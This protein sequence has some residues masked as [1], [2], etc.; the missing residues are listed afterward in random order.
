[1]SGCQILYTRIKTDHYFAHVREPV[2]HLLLR[3][4]ALPA[5]RYLVRV[6]QVRVL[7]M[8]YQPPFKHGGRLFGKILFAPMF[9]QFAFVFVVAALGRSNW[10][11]II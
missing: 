6:L 9:G 11:R 7:H 5:Q 8:L 1:M 2:L 10:L 3:E 4:A